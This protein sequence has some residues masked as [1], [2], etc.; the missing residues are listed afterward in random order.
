VKTS[1]VDHSSTKEILQQKKELQRL[2]KAHEDQI[3]NVKLS[4]RAEVDELKFTHQEQVDSEVQR[5]EQVLAD[6]RESLAKTKRMTDHEIKQIQ[7]DS[8]KVKSNEKILL[9]NQLGQTKS[10]YE[11]VLQDKNHQFNSQMRDMNDISQLRKEDLKITKERELVTENNNWLRK[12]DESKTQFRTKRDTE[13]ELYERLIKKQMNT[14]Q[15]LVKSD[16]VKNQNQLKAMNDKHIV[17]HDQI[18]GQNNKQLLDQGTFYEKKFQDS[19]SSHATTLKDLQGRYDVELTKI[20]QSMSKETELSKNASDD[21]FF[22]FVDLKPEMSLEDNMVVVKVK[23][24]E[25]AKNQLRLTLNNKDLII[26]F[27]RS[28]QDKRTDGLNES[29]ISKVET[30]VNKLKS[31][32]EV[33][34]KKIEQSY[35]DG[36][37]T[38]KI[39]RLV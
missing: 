38:Y 5:K 29:K 27:D 16:Y 4:Q 25:Y 22:D 19:L 1:S 2:K 36:V 14:H 20:K 33:N 35:A 17:Y 23:M 10:H 31:P 21:P 18:A 37:M 7:K 13:Q 11:A 8:E 28:Y 9:E 6:M 15:K 39:A 26:T 3:Q 24:P 12:I 30:L 32:V 34:P